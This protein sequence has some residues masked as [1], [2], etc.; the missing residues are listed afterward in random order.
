MNKHIMFL[1]LFI[2]HLSFFI[3]HSSI[4][5]AIEVGGHLIEDTIWGP[6]NNP[7]LVID[8]V[9]VDEDVTLTI[10]PGTEIKLNAT[11]LESEQTQANFVYYNGANIAKMI[12][13]DGKLVA[14]GTEEDQIIFTRIQDSLYYHWGIIYITEDADRCLFNNCRFEYSAYLLIALGRI[15]FGAIST[16]NEEIV[17]NDCQFVD[18]LCGIHIKGFP[19]KILIN[20]NGFSNIESFSPSY[21]G[22]NLKGGININIATTS[23]P[24]NILIANNDFNENVAYTYLMNHRAPIYVVYNQFVNDGLHAGDGITKPSYFFENDFVDCYQGIEGGSSG[25]SLYIKSNNFI[26]SSGSVGIEIEEAYVE[27][28]DNYFGGCTLDTELQSS[29]IVY[30]NILVNSTFCPSSYL[31]VYNNIGYNGTYG[32]LITYRNEKCQNNMSVK[33]TY[34]FDGYNTGCIENCIFLGNENITQYGVA[35]YPTIRNCIL[36]FE[37]PPECIDGGGNIIV[38]SLQA[39]SIFED[40]QNG[41]FHLAPGSIAIDAG[42]DTLGFYY[43][44]DLDYNQRIWDGN[45][46]GSA[47]IDIGPYEYGAPAFG[48]IQGNTYDPIT[49]LPVD[50]VL[51]K[52]NNIAGEFTFS[53]SVGSYEYKLPAGI[54]DVYAER[55]F[56]DDAVEY[57]IE[58]FDGEF[59][60]WDI[61]MY[62]TVEITQHLIPKIQNLLKNYPNPFNP[63][64]TISFTLTTKDAKD[65]KVEI[66]NLKGQKIREFSIFNFK[67]SI[68]WDGTDQTGK[69]VSSGIYFARLKSGKTEAS[70][71]MLL[72]K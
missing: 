60:E 25:D 31:E 11:L 20:D 67:S 56:Y 38:D 9:F 42:F 54:Y 14:D 33:N 4:A 39:Q 34:A 1:F 64:T 10:M 15:P 55:V 5:N 41:N 13:V 53:D 32:L 51:I 69:P 16:F 28:S 27:I 35:G 44:F 59:T 30:N 24:D 40:I 65:A 61:P 52:I 21:T 63:S 37:L 50:Y 70:C 71:K 17:I 46:N 23:Y 58:V 68:V 45:N 8:D 22:Y 6:E 47:I 7:Y 72:L 3:F 18:N 29:G 19:Q 66:Y 2:S 43:P 36:D 48:G 62:D 26:S 12:Q 57:Q 49:C